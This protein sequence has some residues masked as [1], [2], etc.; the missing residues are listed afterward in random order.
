[1]NIISNNFYNSLKH[2]YL[3]EIIKSVLSN[4]NSNEKKEETKKTEEELENKIPPATST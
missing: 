1:M 4:A 3:V 2:S